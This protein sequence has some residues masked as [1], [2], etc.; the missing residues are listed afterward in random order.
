MKNIIKHRD[1]KK[2][3]FLV[4]EDGTTIQTHYACGLKDKA[5]W[6][7]YHGPAWATWKLLDMAE[8]HVKKCSVCEEALLL[9]IY[10]VDFVENE[11]SVEMFVERVKAMAAASK[12]FE[13][14]IEKLAE[15][16]V[17]KILGAVPTDSSVIAE[18]N[19]ARENYSD[20]VLIR[21]LESGVPMGIRA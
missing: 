13:A 14:A 7:H 16:L 17:I 18:Y 6:V 2:V 9:D 10:G 11:Q 3:Q 4:L 19:D 5:I 21:G 8:T 1:P 12:R 20:E 15:S